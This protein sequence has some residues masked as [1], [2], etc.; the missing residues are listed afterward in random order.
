MR[1]AASRRRLWD[2]L[3][4][5]HPAPCRPVGAQSGSISPMEAAFPVGSEGVHQGRESGQGTV[6]ERVVYLTQRLC[7][8]EVVVAHSVATLSSALR[9]LQGESVDAESSESSSAREDNSAARAMDK[10][11]DARLRV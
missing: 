6:D 7:V 3:Q 2:C 8:L 11:M 10:D 1:S 5:V 4:R 9:D